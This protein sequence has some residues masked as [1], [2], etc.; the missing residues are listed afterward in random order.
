MAKQQANFIE[1][2]QGKRRFIL[3]KMQA[4]IVT[5]ISYAATRGQTDEEGAIQRI[6]N[7]SRIGSIKDFTLGGGDYPNAIVLNWISDT[8][9]IVRVDGKIQFNDERDSAQ[10]I[11]GQHRVAGIKAAIEERIEIGKLEVPVV[12]YDNLSTK[13]CADIF[14]AI[15]TEQKPVPRSLVFDLYGIASEELVDPAAVRARDIAIYLDTENKSP[16]YGEIKFPGNKTRKGGIALSTAVSAIKPLVEEKGGFEQIDI[17]S[18]ES[19]SKIIMN[20]FFALQIKYGD[21]WDDK[22]NAFMFAAGFM[23][24]LEFLKL[25]LIPYCNLQKS[26]EIAT[27]AN[28]IN[29]TE[30]SLIRQEELKGFGGSAATKEVYER[31]IASF[32]PKQKLSAKIKI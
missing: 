7:Q 25:K 6:L 27:I 8:N 1:I 24:A 2:T 29:L 22:S 4:N 31:L 13:E 14:L 18:L 12:I 16:Y 30:N 15:N 17:H 9:K 19:Q 28:A 32:K 23:G 10:I 3:T 5:K 26:F 20:L 11:D 21:K